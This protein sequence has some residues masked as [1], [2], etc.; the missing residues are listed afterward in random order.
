MVKVI[1]IVIIIIVIIME[2]M[3]SY[4]VALPKCTW[5]V[6]KTELEQ[7]N[8]FIVIVINNMIFI[9]IV[10]TIVIQGGPKQRLPTFTQHFW[11]KNS[12][13]DSFQVALDCT[14]QNTRIVDKNNSSVL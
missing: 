1:I 6:A 5:G 3:Q 9:V 13:C 11:R 10:I 4:P 7:V 12:S 14:L 2:G 8:L